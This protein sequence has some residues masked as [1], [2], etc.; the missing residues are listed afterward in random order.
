MVSLPIPSCNLIFEINLMG[1]LNHRAR[2]G[3]LIPKILIYHRCSS[4]CQVMCHHRWDTRVLLYPI[5]WFDIFYTNVGAPQI[6]R[7]KM[8]KF[9]IPVI[10][11]LMIRVISKG[12]HMQKDSFSWV[13]PPF[14]VYV[15]FVLFFFCFVLFCFVFLFLFFGFVCFCFCLF[16]FVCLFV[17]FFVFL[18]FVFIRLC[19]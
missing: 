6:H 9:N 3:Y 10:N 8:E 4:V 16:V 12:K 18:V 15:F 5:N 19:F 14:I 11:P 1:T 13:S 2:K 17:C 7:R